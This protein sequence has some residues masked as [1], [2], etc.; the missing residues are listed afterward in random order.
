MIKIRKQD[1]DKIVSQ[2]FDG[3]PCEICGLLGGTV[4]GNIREVKKVYPLT[5]MDHS[6]EH[7]SMDPREQLA[8]VKDMRAN[9][10]ALLGNYHSHPETPSRPSQED[11]RLAR[12]PGIA[13]LILSLQN[14]DEP[15]LKAFR[16]QGG[17]VTRE[18]LKITD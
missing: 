18:E 14:Q 9:S 3:L 11:I 13:Y 15:M 6:N 4:T 7:F 16:I 10:L 17:E 2:A 5:N 12:D 1:Y 8:A